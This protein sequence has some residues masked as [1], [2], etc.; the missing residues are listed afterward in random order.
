MAAG[1]SA[2]QVMLS[3][4]GKEGDPYS[5]ARQLPLQGADLKNKI[6]Q[7]SN[8]VAAGVTQGVGYAMGCRK[9]GR[10]PRGERV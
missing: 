6:I 2:E 9:I 1:L 5:G 3:F 10:A 8:V 4:M 7:I